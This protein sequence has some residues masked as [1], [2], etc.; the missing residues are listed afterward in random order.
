MRDYPMSDH[1]DERLPHE[2]PPWW[3]TTLMRLPHKWPPWWETTPPFKTVFSLWPFPNHNFHA[4]RTLPDFYSWFTKPVLEG[5]PSMS[6]II[7]LPTHSYKTSE[8][9]KVHA[10]LYPCWEVV[11]LVQGPEAAW[12]ACLFIIGW[13]GVEGETNVQAWSSPVKPKSSL[14]LLSNRYNRCPS[15]ANHQRR[16]FARRRSEKRGDSASVSGLSLGLTITGL[17][18]RTGFGRWIISARSLAMAASSSSFCRCSLWRRWPSSSTSRSFFHS[19]NSSRCTARR[20]ELSSK[21]DTSVGH[22]RQ[23]RKDSNMIV[24]FCTDQKM[25]HTNY[26]T[27]KKHKR[28]MNRAGKLCTQQWH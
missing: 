10:I 19:S 28:K 9:A 4:K 2:R 25:T 22:K 11:I 23:R 1:P 17:Y 3:E 7:L 27:K 15:S 18:R 16:T 26:K 8:E 20:S 6:C 12:R 5:A 21:S 13:G 24:Y 14:Y